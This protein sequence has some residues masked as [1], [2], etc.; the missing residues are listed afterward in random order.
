MKLRLLLLVASLISAPPAVA[1][2]PSTHQI[3]S[4]NAVIASDINKDPSVMSQLGLPPYAAKPTFSAS[5][6]F[7]PPAT[8]S[9]LFE[10]GA[11][12]EDDDTRSLH[13]FFNPLTNAS[14]YT[15]PW[16][17]SPD[18]TVSA[19]DDPSSVKLSFQQARE[20]LWLATA[21]PLNSYAYRQKQ[22]GMMFE[23][24]G[25]V[26][27][28]L[29]DMA[30]PQIVSQLGTLQQATLGNEMA[31]YL[32]VRNTTNGPQ[33]FLIYFLLGEDGVWRIDGM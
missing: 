6:L 30:Q 25:H 2:K 20:Y 17:D 10:K 19:P 13:H 23:S 9:E 12:D 8:I 24:L 15:P 18:W 14:M 29:K 16:S 11:I 4:R 27:H 21:N 32:L 5:A 31:E 3:M 28:H 33:G 1:Y 22:F 7:T 26:I